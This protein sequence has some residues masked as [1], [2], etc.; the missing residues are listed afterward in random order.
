MRSLGERLRMGLGGGTG[1][2]LVDACIVRGYLENTEGVRSLLE[3]LAYDGRLEGLV[4]QLALSVVWKQDPAAILGSDPSESHPCI[5]RTV[6]VGKVADGRIA[7]DAS[8]DRWP[9]RVALHPL[10]AAEGVPTI[11][12]PVPA[13]PSDDHDGD[14]QTSDGGSIAEGRLLFIGASAIWRAID[15]APDAI[16]HK[17]ILNAL[18]RAGFEKNDSGRFC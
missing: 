15:A 3:L 13:A 9:F 6:H 1:S 12:V 17:A 11:L 2:A 10:P 7:I 4:G 16:A 14:I 5:E 18:Y 8:D